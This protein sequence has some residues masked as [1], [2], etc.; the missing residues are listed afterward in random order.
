MKLPS[1]TDEQYLAHLQQRIAEENYIVQQFLEAEAFAKIG[2]R[3]GQY[4]EA[5]EAGQQTINQL[6][7]KYMRVLHEE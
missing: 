3:E 1:E 5:I 4:Q 6:T 2:E 7:E